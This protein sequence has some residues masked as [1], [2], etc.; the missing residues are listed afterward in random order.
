MERNEEGSNSPGHKLCPF[1]KAP[2]I[3]ATCAVWMA[4]EAIC[5]FALIPPGYRRPPVQKPKPPKT[6]SGISGKFHDPLFG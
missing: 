6:T 2:C 5:T 3:G 1:D 4:E